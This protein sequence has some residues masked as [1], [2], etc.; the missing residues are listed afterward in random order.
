ME[1]KYK[2]LTGEEFAKLT[3]KEKED[4]L[5]EVVG[6]FI[7]EQKSSPPEFEKVFE[8]NWEDLLY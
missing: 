3:D 2:N 6:K 1:N 8:E 7:S 5:A 4:A